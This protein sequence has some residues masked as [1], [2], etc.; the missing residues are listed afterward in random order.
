M[1]SGV[2]AVGKAVMPRLL[3]VVNVDWFLISHRLPVALAAHRAG[4]EVHVATRFTGREEELRQ[5]GFTVH[6]LPLERGRANPVALLREF[7]AIYRLMRKISPD[8]AHFVTIKPVLLGGLAA[9][10]TKVGGILAAISGLGTV[11]LSKGWRARIRRHA[12]EVL[13]KLALGH[14]NLQ[15]VVQNS[16]DLA[17]LQR[18]TGLSEVAFS[19]IPGS[20]I[21]TKVFFPTES[22]SPEAPVVMFAGRLLKDK[23][24]QE[25]IDAVRLLK[26]Q[27]NGVAE[28]HFVLVGD[29]DPENQTSLSL[30]AVNSWQREGI[31]EWWGHRDDMATTL[32]RAHIVVLP[33]YREGM[34]KVLLEAAACGL[35]VVTSDVPG[36]RDAIRPDVTG[37]LVKV[38]D[39]HS[40]ATALKK[41]LL[42]PALRMQMGAAGR[43]LAED[44]FRVESVV[45]AHLAIYKDLLRNG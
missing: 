19:L 32:N 45:E 43:I 23:G 26:S 18:M 30:A 39:P 4:Y 22:R 27:G 33:S 35:P 5:V 14:R 20:G 12:V 38:G 34:P 28:A 42:D 25:F 15:V 1:L 16:D 9:R 3:L 24:V 21:D 41:L 29:V 8:V 11:F 31:V 40:L 13:Y 44:C 17:M 10:L 36:C 2:A 7:L 6:S 37:L